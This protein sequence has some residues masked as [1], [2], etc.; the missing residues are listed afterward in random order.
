MLRSLSI[1]DDSGRPGSSLAIMRLHCCYGE[2]LYCVL[3][4]GIGMNDDHVC[5]RNA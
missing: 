2:S 5:V 1:I 4:G 3:I